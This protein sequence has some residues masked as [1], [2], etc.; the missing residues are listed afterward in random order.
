M[1]KLFILLFFITGF[2]SL[3]AWGADFHK[4]VAAFKSGDYVTALSEWTPLA[5]QGDADAQLSLG[6]SY[7]EGLGVSQNYKTAVKWI[8]LAA[9]QGLAVAQ[10]MLGNHYFDGS[11]VPQNYKT[12]MKWFKL[13]AEQGHA[14]SQFNLGKSYV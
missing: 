5:E 7:N 4:G 10:A 8:S 12:A 13:A 9:K 11:G 14:S 3:Q 1:K 2:S 6:Y